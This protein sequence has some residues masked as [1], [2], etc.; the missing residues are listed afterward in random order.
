MHTM[1]ETGTTQDEARMDCLKGSLGQPVARWVSDRWLLWD[2]CIIGCC[3]SYRP[4]FLHLPDSDGMDV[5]LFRWLSITWLHWNSVLTVLITICHSWVLERHAAL[6]VYDM[7]LRWWPRHNENPGQPLF[8]CDRN[9][10]YIMWIWKLKKT[11]AIFDLTESRFSFVVNS[12]L[13]WLANRMVWIR[14]CCQKWC[15]CYLFTFVILLFYC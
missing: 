11:K 2:F 14:E 12:N 7:C 5:A 13:A 3:S 1:S 6:I 8:V 9:K 10:Q 4:S 15:H